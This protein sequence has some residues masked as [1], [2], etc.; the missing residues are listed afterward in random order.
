MQWFSAFPLLWGLLVSAACTPTLTPEEY[1]ERAQIAA[2]KIKRS[3]DELTLLEAAGKL[4]VTNGSEQMNSLESDL[5]ALTTN[6]K[7]A[8]S[9]GHTVATYLLANLQN[10][11]LVSDAEHKERCALYQKAMDQGLLAAAV[12]YYHLC[13]KAYE[14]FDLQN[15][16]HLKLLLTLQQL[17]QKSDINSHFYPLPSMRSLCFEDMGSS[18]PTEGVI[19]A[20]QAR[21]HALLLTEDQYRAE[22]N[23]ILAV[24]SVNASEQP[25]GQNIAYIDKAETLGC[26]DYS[27]LIDMIRSA[28]KVFGE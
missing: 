8:S 13:D 26:K 27:G 12:G 10:R 18:L 3:T 23:L 20:L 11:G 9:G 16:D 4:N 19:S 15:P 17:L 7:N 5:A 6:L 1:F 21:S 25:D 24:T 22:A 2:E 14:R 28:V